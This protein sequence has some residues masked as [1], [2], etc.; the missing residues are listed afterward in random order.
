MLSSGFKEAETRV[1]QL[2]EDLPHAVLHFCCI[3]HGKT[4]EL[5]MMKAD[6]IRG[7][8]VFADKY[9]CQETIGPYLLKTLQDYID[10]SNVVIEAPTTAPQFPILPTGIGIEDMIAFAVIF[11]ID[12]LLWRTTKAFMVSSEHPLKEIGYEVG[13]PALQCGDLHLYG[14]Y[15]AV[16]GNGQR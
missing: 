7:L 5:K 16:S 6:I 11:K 1:I 2:P 10:W 3:I 13:L 4:D 12:S 8:I 15:S 9:Q 14:E